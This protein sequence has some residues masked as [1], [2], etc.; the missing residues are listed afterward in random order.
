MRSIASVWE[1]SREHC[2]SVRL[3]R[4]SNTS[5]MVTAE[6][7]HLQFKNKAQPETVGPAS[8][9]RYP[10]PFFRYAEVLSRHPLFRPYLALAAVCFFWGTTYLGIRMSLE[11]FPPLM[12]VSVRFIISGSILLLFAKTRGLY[13]PRG[14]ELAA[15][16]FSGV[17][18][19]GVGNG[20]L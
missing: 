17:L 5:I 15:A 16:C 3:S 19:L 11:A 2:C 7:Y 14:R 13:L 6:A 8:G 18:T 9:P 4:L 10:A 12:L 20:A 1:M